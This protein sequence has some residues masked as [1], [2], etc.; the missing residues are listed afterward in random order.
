MKKRTYVIFSISFCIFLILSYLVLTKNDIYIDTYIYNY[1]SKFINPNMTYFV[2]ILTNIGGAFVVIFI[3]IL[4]LIVLKRKIYS[5]LISINLILI[6]VFQVMLKH[7]FLRSRPL[8]INLI[9]E[10]GYSFPSGHSITAFV[11]YG[12]I[13]YLIYKSN[14]NNKLKSI[15]IVILSLFIFIVGFSRIYLGVHFFTDV[16]G[17][18]SFGICYLIIYINIVETHYLK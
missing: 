11:F 6:T 7:I 1:V 8:D 17:A 14:I 13:I 10:T 18:F 5:F 2:K 15:Y 12:F 16:L 3:S 9:D 4:S